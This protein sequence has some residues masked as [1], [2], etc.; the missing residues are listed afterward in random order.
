MGVSRIMES[1]AGVCP[2][3]RQHSGK[4]LTRGGRQGGRDTVANYIPG[5]IYIPTVLQPT[6][7]PATVMKECA[8]VYV[9]TRRAEKSAG[10]A[11]RLLMIARLMS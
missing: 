11:A 7:R 10:Q 8:G 2:S 1:G 9:V 6:N 4:Q 3:I 5:E